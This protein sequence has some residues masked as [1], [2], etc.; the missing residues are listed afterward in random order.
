MVIVYD[1][2]FLLFAL[3]YLPYLIFTGRYHKDIWQRF[4][5]YPKDTVEDLKG[6]E[7]IWVHA[8][9]VGEVMAARM[10]CEDILAKISGR[11]L[12]ISTITKTGNDMARRLFGGRAEIL[13]LPVDL[14]FVTDGVF[15]K[16]RPELFV[17]VETEI[18]PNLVISLKKRGIPIV[19]VNGRIS[20]L[21]FRRYI[22]IRFFIKGV[23]EKITLFCM[24]TSD[25]AERIKKMGAP[26]DRVVVTGN[27]KFDAA[28]SVSTALDVDTIRHDLGLKNDEPLFIAGSTHRPE[29]GIVLRVYK[30]LVRDIPNLRLLIA[31]RHIERVSEV[32]AVIRRAGFAPL[33][34][35][36][37][38]QY[39]IRP[40]TS[41]GAG[42]TPFDLAQ[43]RQYKTPVL[44]LDT[45][46]RLGQIYSIG[47]VVFMGGSLMR[48]GGQNI[49]EPAVFSKPTIFGPHMFNFKDIKDAFLNEDAACMVK[50]ENGLS[51]TAGLL[52]NN[53]EMRK[54]LGSRASALIRKN[55][56]ATQ[57]NTEEILKII[58]KR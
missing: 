38:T 21:S 36:M 7:I 53:E 5:L 50:D 19:M 58:K 44:L 13:Y 35:S 9:S 23:L 26:A 46:G 18:W 10:L 4:G 57:R 22:K 43:G 52:L 3:A 51:R 41:L 15:D 48:K 1:I 39:A 34:I 17:I 54:D 49:L 30:R 47:T 11:K 2:I 14:S 29:E 42:N 8:V 16:I 45:M 32:E 25:Y 28:G 6:K 33:R 40:S 55:R 37:I 12:V 31:P 56:G 27:M 20:P 24:Q